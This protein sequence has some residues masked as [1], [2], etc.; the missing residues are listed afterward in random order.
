ML[1][2]ANRLLMQSTGGVVSSGSYIGT[3]SYDSTSVAS[4]TFSGVSVGSADADRY[5]I[6]SVS[7]RS[8]SASTN[9]VSISCTIGGVSATVVDSFVQ[10]N[11]EACYIFAASLPT[12]TTADIV[13][14]AASATFSQAVVGVYRLIHASG[15]KY[16]SGRST[17]NNAADVTVTI[18]TPGSGYLVAIAGIQG[19][20]AISWTSGPTEDFETV[21]TSLVSAGASASG[22]LGASTTTTV[23]NVDNV[24]SSGRRILVVAYWQF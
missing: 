16:S 20:S 8:A 2:L 6:A 24:G 9:F 18:S 17:S 7:I 1:T 10:S 21:T 22:T 12:G 19:S 14:T 5:V 23:A 3:H 11:D 15:V 4:H 13:L